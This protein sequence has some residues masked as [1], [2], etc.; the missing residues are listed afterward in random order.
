M[1]AA[2][3]ALAKGFNAGFRRDANGFAAV[4]APALVPAL[5]PTLF[6]VLDEEVVFVLEP[7][8]GAS[9]PGAGKAEAAPPAE[10]IPA[11]GSIILGELH[12]LSNHIRIGEHLSKHGT[13]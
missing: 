10:P 9:P 13:L 4:L 2:F 5:V 3:P 1:D 8:S 7:S 12:A 6:P 11:L